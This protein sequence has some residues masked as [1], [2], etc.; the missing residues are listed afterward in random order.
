MK[1]TFEV[2]N[3]MVRNGAIADYAIAGAIGAIFYVEPFA[4]HDIDV[5][6]LMPESDSG[7]IAE[8]PGWDYLKRC[9]YSEIRE[10][11]IVVE[12]WPVQFIPVGDSLER[13]AYLNAEVLFVE[14]TRVRVVLAEH[15]VAIMLRVGRPK[16]LARIQMFLSQEAV[17]L[18]A[19]IDI[20][21][22]HGLEEKW[23]AFQDK[24]L[25]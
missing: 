21:K 6:V 11:A 20:I 22:R 8:M 18:E 15:L 25:P 3:E 14:E 1:K 17:E 7:L 12:G 2:L 23:A 5:F 16:D 13:E 10:E 24:V 9:G 4:T 19:L